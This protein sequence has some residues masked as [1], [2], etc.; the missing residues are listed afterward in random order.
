MAAIKKQTNQKLTNVG[1]DVKRKL[2]A[3]ALLVGMSNSTAN[4]GNS[5]AASQKMKGNFTI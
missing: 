5:M 3:C 4:V 1:E 2:E